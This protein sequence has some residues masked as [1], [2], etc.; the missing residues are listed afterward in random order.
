MDHQMRGWIPFCLPNT[1]SN[2][3]LPTNHGFT[4]IELMIVVAIA[5]VLATFAVPAYQDYLQAAN[6]S[7]VDIHYQRAIVWVQSEMQ[8]L[9]VQISTGSSR[10]EVSK[11]YASA[12]HWV[13]ALTREDVRSAT[14]S[15]EGAA[16]Y[17]AQSDT[18]DADG[19]VL[20]TLAG[21][22]AKGTAKVTIRRPIYG[23]FTTAV[24]AK[25]CWSQSVC[26]D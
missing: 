24:T 10:A 14:A 7:K 16:A 11:K 3:L 12:S 20:L 5:G 15:P 23:D 18:A 1:R 6:S 19:T 13:V 9:R 26:G 2:L 17:A 22:I 8:R 25:V 21:S 4:L